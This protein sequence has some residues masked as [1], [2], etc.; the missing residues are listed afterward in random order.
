M[1]CARNS[2]L[3]LRVLSVAM[4]AL[5]TCSTSGDCDSQEKT[6]PVGKAEPERNA[7]NASAD[8]SDSFIERAPDGHLIVEL[9]DM[10]FGASDA[11]LRKELDGMKVELVGQWVTRGKAP[12]G[13]EQFLA[14]KLFRDDDRVFGTPTGPIIETDHPPQLPA[15]TWV[16]ITGTASFPVI[17][18]KRQAVV[19]AK[20][21]EK[22][23]AP[24][25]EFRRYYMVG[26]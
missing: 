3:L 12:G 8:G 19:R 23:E 1:K 2:A 7:S 6:S 20:T 15:M 17:D 14:A 11:V 24:A 4:L 13:G 10:L 18:G 26:C 5:L 25:D 21:I 16:K 22:T 9:E